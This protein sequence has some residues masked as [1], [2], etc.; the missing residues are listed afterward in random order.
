[1]Q[2]QLAPRPPIA[3]GVVAS[4]AGATAGMDVSDSLVMDAGRIARA[5]NVVIHLDENSLDDLAGHLAVEVGI[6]ASQARQAILFGGEDHALLMTFPNAGSVPQTYTIIG[7]V[8]AVDASMGPH[9][10]LGGAPVHE[11]GW[12]PYSGWNG[13]TS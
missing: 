5:S 7:H 12:N 11:N 3:Q 10:N 1:M 2:A 9:V 8:E 13:E 6:D 4:L